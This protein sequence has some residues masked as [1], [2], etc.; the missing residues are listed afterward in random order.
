MKRL[1]RRTYTVRPGDTL[2]GIAERFGADVE[3]LLRWNGIRDARRIRPGQEP[4]S[5]AAPPQ[6]TRRGETRPGS[7]LA[8]CA[9]SSSCSRFDRVARRVVRASGSAS[10]MIGSGI[11]RNPTAL[12]PVCIAMVAGA[13]ARKRVSASTSSTSP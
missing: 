13:L 12:T 8:P 4:A 11:S 1:R 10:M 3:D 9:S 2:G 5:R 6:P 7:G